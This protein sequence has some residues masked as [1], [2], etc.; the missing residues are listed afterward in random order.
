MWIKCLISSS[1][2]SRVCFFSRYCI[3]AMQTGSTKL[4]SHSTAFSS[5][6]GSRLSWRSANLIHFNTY[7]S[8]NPATLICDHRSAY[9]LFLPFHFWN[10]ASISDS[11]TIYGSLNMTRLAQYRQGYGYNYYGKHLQC[12]TIDLNFLRV[13][14]HN[15]HQQQSFELIASL[16]HDELCHLGEHCLGTPNIYLNHILFS[17][18]ATSCVFCIHSTSPLQ[19][20]TKIVFYNLKTGKTKVLLP[21]CII[22]H[23]CFISETKLLI[24]IIKNN[25]TSFILYDLEDFSYRLF[26]ITTTLMVTRVILTP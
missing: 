26:L 22:S 9:K 19:K 14:K 3:Y 17:P 1:R 24:C 25:Q 23:H 11:E 18:D 8:A 15:I 4:L 5:Q 10:Y 7:N 2:R 12:H 13:Y 6:L 16:E 20:D 21:E